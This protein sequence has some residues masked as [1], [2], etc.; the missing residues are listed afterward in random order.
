[1]TFDPSASSGGGGGGGGSGLPQIGDGTFTSSALSSGAAFGYA[2]ADSTI[3][4]SGE[5]SKAVGY[6]YNATINA[7]GTGAQAS[8]FAL[9]NG[10]A[11]GGAI[12]ASGSGSFAH[13]R[14]YGYA[15]HGTNTLAQIAA[16]GYGGVAMGQAY[17]NGRIVAAGTSFAFGYAGS[18]YT[19]YTG[20]INSDRG[21]LA[22]G[23]VYNKGA[24]GVVSAVEP[25]SHVVGYAQAL[26]SYTQVRATAK[27]AAVF[28]YSQN[29]TVTGAGAGSITGGF[30]NNSGTIST[31]LGAWG[32]IAWGYTNAGTISATTTNAIQFG[33]GTN[34]LADSLSVGTTIRLKGTTSAPGTP[35]NGDMWV[36]S[37]YVYIR[38]NGATVK[39]V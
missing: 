39:I 31:S 37:D 20:M 18:Y 21:A 34:S 16:P 11:N 3:V 29:S 9:N 17:N 30:V 19:D 32:S 10:Y 24:D 15:V 36:A 14:V 25:G 4:A 33:P 8:G 22:I 6:A 23:N 26:T 1:M 5:G 7:N 28:A 38:S 35:R 13:G 12:N 2:D 27:G